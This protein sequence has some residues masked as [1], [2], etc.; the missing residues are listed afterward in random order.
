MILPILKH[1]TKSLHQRSVEITTEELLQPDTQ[2]FIDNMLDS[3]K[4]EKSGVG[5]ASPQV[6]TNKRIIVVDHDGERR[7]YVNPRITSTSS[8]TVEFEEGCL[9][10]PNVWGIVRRFKKVHVKALD[11][12]G[13]KIELKVAGFDAII[14][15]HEIDHLDGILFIDRAERLTKNSS[16][17]L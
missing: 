9:S 17:A 8:R 7:V 16:S 1:P 3:L 2:T 6:G 13:K 5:I 4:A 11:R 10:V 15:Q 12:K 14:F